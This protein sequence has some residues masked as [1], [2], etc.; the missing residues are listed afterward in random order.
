MADVADAIRYRLSDYSP[1]AA[2]VAARIYPE[3]AP[4]GA[5]KPYVRYRVLSATQTETFG[6][7]INPSRALI[8]IGTVARTYTSAQAVGAQIQNALER[9]SGTSLGVV[10]QH[11]FTDTEWDVDW[12]EE[13]EA[14]TKEQDFIVWYE[15]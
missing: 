8:Q 15:E 4:Q 2:L 11:V 10:I 3:A 1:L 12:D 13:L 6:G 5:T 9:W 7:T 14:H